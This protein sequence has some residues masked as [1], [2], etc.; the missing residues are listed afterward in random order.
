MANSV[1]EPKSFDFAV[2]IVDLYKHLN[3]EKKYLFFQSNCF[4]PEQA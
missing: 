1:I 2:G 4:A 3:G